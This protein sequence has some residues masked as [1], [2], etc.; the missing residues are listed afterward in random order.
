MKVDTRRMTAMNFMVS[1]STIM[2]IVIVQWKVQDFVC[3][4]N[5]HFLEVEEKDGRR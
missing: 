3:K 2:V 5:F 4:F 1:V